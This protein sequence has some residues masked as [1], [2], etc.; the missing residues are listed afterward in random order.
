MAKPAAGTLPSD[1][2]HFYEKLVATNPSVKREGATVPYTSLN[3]HMS[4]KYSS[5]NTTP[6]CAKP[7]AW[8]NANMS[9]FRLRCFPLR[10]N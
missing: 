8:V 3:G 9:K 2:L 4:A 1:K 5:K 7:M 10:G 6:N